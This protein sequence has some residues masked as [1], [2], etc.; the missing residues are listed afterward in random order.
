MRISDWSSDVCSSDLFRTRP[1]SDRGGGTVLAGEN[2]PGESVSPGQRQAIER[3]AGQRIAGTAP[4]SGGCIGTVLRIDLA[5]GS[6]LVA[7]LAGPGGDLE[8]EGYKIGRAHV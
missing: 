2:S 3:A 5:D 8:L 1:R 6:R 4:L 7:K